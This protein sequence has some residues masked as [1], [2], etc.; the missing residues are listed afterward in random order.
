MPTTTEFVADFSARD[1]GARTDDAAAAVD[2]V[3]AEEDRFAQFVLTQ[4]VLTG[5]A[6]ITSEDSPAGMTVEVGSNAAKEDYAVL[7]GTSLGQGNYIVRGNDAKTTL[8][9][10]AA[11]PTNPRIDEVYIIVLDDLY[12]TSGKGIVKYAVRTGDPA[13]SPSAP[14]PDSSW[15]AYFLL[16]TIQ[17]AAGVTSIVDAN[18]T[19]QRTYTGIKLFD[20]E[21]LGTN[22]LEDTIVSAP[23]GSFVSLE[24]DGTAIA[25]VEDGTPALDM[26]G[27]DLVNLP[28]AAGA[29]ADTPFSTHEHEH[30]QRDNSSAWPTAVPAASGAGIDLIVGVGQPLDD[31]NAAYLCMAYAQISSSGGAGAPI[32]WR[33][34][35]TLSNVGGTAGTGL[36]FFEDGQATILDNGDKAEL[37]SARTI[38]STG[39]AST[40]YLSVTVRRSGVTGVWQVNF[41]WAIAIKM[42][43]RAPIGPIT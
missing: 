34:G 6:F 25:R 1:I 41:M 5:G 4:G 30:V 20:S 11:D 12:D 3:T 16:S 37:F 17:V 35:P 19:D 28:S 7:V 27:N 24:I 36:G 31:Q 18:I 9:I 10:A 13:A 15:D 2:D 21:R 29:A 26:L 32:N 8:T 39:V 43:N 14:G 40:D 23:S 22:D 38:Q 42:T 33:M